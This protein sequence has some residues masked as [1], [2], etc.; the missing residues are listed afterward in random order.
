M[1]DIWCDDLIQGALLV[2]NLHYPGLL[3]QRGFLCA[4]H[5]PLTVTWQSSLERCSLLMRWKS[6]TNEWRV[7]GQEGSLTVVT[8]VG[9]RRSFLPLMTC[10]PPLVCQC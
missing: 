7:K 8:F 4:A 5:S 6:R 10:R 9:G 1:D 2:T 3:E